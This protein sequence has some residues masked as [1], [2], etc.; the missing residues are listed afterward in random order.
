MTQMP[1]SLPFPHDPLT[2]NSGSPRPIAGRAEMMSA[3]GKRA[4][5][6]A[7][8]ES[9]ALGKVERCV[10]RQEL[11]AQLQIYLTPPPSFSWIDQSRLQLYAADTVS[12]PE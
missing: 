5:V 10:E 9:G 12:T 1:T 3:F 2:P 6:S 7:R 11:D 8:R 4:T